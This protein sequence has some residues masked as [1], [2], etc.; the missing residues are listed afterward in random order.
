ML[1]KYAQKLYLNISFY[2]KETQLFCFLLC[3]LIYFSFVLVML[4][5]TL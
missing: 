2:C 3:E 4:I 5:D 1:I